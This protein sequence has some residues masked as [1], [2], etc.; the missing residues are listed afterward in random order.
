MLCNAL[1]QPHFDYACPARHL[2]LNEKTKKKIQIMQNKCIR[3]CLKLDKMHNISEVEFRFINWLPISISVD[4]CINFVNTCPCYL[5]E[6]FEFAPHC[7]IGIRNNFFK[8]KN[9]FRKT[10]MGQKT[11]SYTGPSIWS[12]LPDSIKKRIVYI[13]SNVMPKST[14]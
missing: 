9:P 12:S 8:L 1:I 13:L 2:N 5:N 11:I 3:F 6:I 14:I 7:S 10:N 4:Q